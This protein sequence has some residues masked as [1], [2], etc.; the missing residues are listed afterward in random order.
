MTLI[1][2]VLVVTPSCAVTTT[3][4][5]LLPVLKVIGPEGLPLATATPFTLTVA[6]AFAVVGVTVMVLLL[7]TTL[8]E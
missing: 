2:Y 4:M 5:T 7:L 6:V 3:V 1:V 8:A